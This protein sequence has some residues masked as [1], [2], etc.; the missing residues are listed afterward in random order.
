[1]LAINT[2]ASI[3]TM[4]AV[5]AISTIL[6]IYTIDIVSA[7]DRSGSVLTLTPCPAVSPV[8]TIG[9]VGASI[10]LITLSHGL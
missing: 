7:L 3:F 10:A 6:A 2:I 8:S 4:G 9:T 5:N 1:M